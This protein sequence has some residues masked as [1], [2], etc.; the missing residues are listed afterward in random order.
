MTSRDLSVY[1]LCADWCDTCRTFQDA[2][3]ALAREFPG[4]RFTWIDIEDESDAVGDYD[5]ET[6]PTVLI[7]VGTVVRFL[8]PVLPGPDSVR[9]LLLA[10]ADASAGFPALDANAQALL[11][12]LMVAG[13]APP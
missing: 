7:A 10:M 8:G 3:R 12:R 6:F 2:W 5:I 13:T 4:H 11:G 9:R 1:C